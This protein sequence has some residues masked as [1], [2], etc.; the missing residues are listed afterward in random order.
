MQSIY[1]LARQKS[2]AA[3]LNPVKVPEAIEKARAVKKRKRRE[4]REAHADQIRADNAKYRE[5]HR[6]QIHQHNADTKDQ[7]AA[8]WQSYYEANREQIL[9]RTRENRLAKQQARDEN[10]LQK[11]RERAKR[12]NEKLRA[13]PVRYA[14]YLEKR[15]NR[16]TKCQKTLTN[17]SEQQ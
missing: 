6:E 17:S 14:A 5:T 8:W 10:Y 3:L 15:K 13:D 9:K 2:E 16:K 12:Y 7:R 11:A 4:Y 1:E